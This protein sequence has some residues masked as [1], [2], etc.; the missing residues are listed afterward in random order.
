MG[1]LDVRISR[2]ASFI[3]AVLCAFFVS[4]AQAQLPFQPFGRLVN[5]S[6]RAHIGTGSDALI[7]GFVI[8]G[9][10]P[11]KLVIRGIGPS[12]KAAAITD[13]LQH[14]IVELHDS[15]GAV[16]AAN[17]GWK[18]SQ[19]QEIEASGLAPADDR[20]AAIIKILN[21]GAYTA[22]LRGS[23][24]ATGT[25]LVEVYDVDAGS[26]SVL[27]NV[28]TRGFVGS[29]NSPMIGG[30]IIADEGTPMNRI[31]ARALGPSL[32]QAGLEKPLDDP[33]LE[34]RDRGARLIA[35]NDDCD[36]AEHGDVLAE[37]SL[38]PNDG[39]EAAVACVV[40]PGAYTAIV[41][42]ANG[43]SGTALVEFYHLR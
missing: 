9:T 13:P 35:S 24:D 11:K 19:Q 29:D 25:G 22:V 30:V 2:R 18:A 32:K 36:E 15:A 4:S 16:I 20:E 6:T 37:N 40:A 31:V 10:A 21:P 39:A 17:D 14:A 41:R 42:S 8:R 7:A 27:V 33:T 38:M 12:L 26:T 1:S 43:G 23:A 28:S 3:V 5:I 34:V